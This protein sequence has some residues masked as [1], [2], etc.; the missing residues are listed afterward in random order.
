M[1][2]GTLLFEGSTKKVLQAEAANQVVL[3]FKDSKTDFDGEKRS[4]FKGKG[5]VRLALTKV[6]FEYLESYNIPTHWGKVIGPDQVQVKKMDMLP[7]RVLIRN[8]AAGSLCERFNIKAGMPLKYPVLEYYL[9]DEALGDPM[10]SES[11]AYAF[12]RCSPDEIK[13]ISRLSSKVNAV[14]KAFID[15]RKLKLVDYTLEFG[16]SQNKIY[17]ADEITPDNARLWYIDEKGALKQNH[18]HLTNSKAEASFREILERLT[19]NGSL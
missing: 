2:G 11:H 9:K 1:A 8:I 7:I 5:A 12:D 6:V 3:E 18:F 10:I 4:G 16:R 14:L 17:L 13:H 19:G 15:R